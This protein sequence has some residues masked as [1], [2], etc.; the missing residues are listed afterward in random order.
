MMASLMILHMLC[1]L[2]FPI[3]GNIVNVCN[4]NNRDMLNILAE[5]A[6]DIPGNFSTWHGNTHVCLYNDKIFVFKQTRRRGKLYRAILT[7]LSKLVS[8][9]QWY[10]L[11][12][13]EFIVKLYAFC[14]RVKQLFCWQYI[15]DNWYDMTIIVGTYR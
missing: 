7:T 5:L 9:S 13:L 2:C 4:N 10:Y 11:L 8:S 14:K 1:L 3:L 6:D 15:D 12:T